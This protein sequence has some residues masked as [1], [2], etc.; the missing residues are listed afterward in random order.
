MRPG[1]DALVQD[2][3][4]GVPRHVFGDVGKPPAGRDDH[5]Q[6]DGQVQPEKTLR[7]ETRPEKAKRPL[8]LHCRTPP[9]PLMMTMTS[10]ELESFARAF[11]MPTLPPKNEN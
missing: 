4:R 6:T 11:L 10:I 5:K 7:R 2:T 8:E 3:S 1:G 9:A